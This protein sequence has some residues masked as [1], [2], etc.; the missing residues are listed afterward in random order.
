MSSFP[1]IPAISQSRQPLYNAIAWVHAVLTHHLDAHEGEA[2]AATPPPCPSLE[3][4]SQHL[5]LS[6]FEAKIVLLC[7][8]MELEPSCAALCAQIARNP[9]KP[10]PTLGLALQVFADADWDILA[11]HRPLWTWKLLQVEE[12]PNPTQARIALEHRILTYLLDVQ[13]LDPKLQAWMQPLGGGLADLAPS[14][15]QIVQRVVNTWQSGK[16]ALVQLC[17][18]DELAKQ[19]IAQIIAQSLG[20]QIYRLQAS[21]LPLT[22]PE[23]VDLKQRWHREAILSQA[24]L[25]IDSDRNPAS[26]S[27]QIEPLTL[28]TTDLNVPLILSSSE[29]FAVRQRTTLTYD[30]ASLTH[31]EKRTI[32]QQNLGDRAAELNGQ[33]EPIIAQ[34]NLNSHMIQAACAATQKIPLETLPETL[35]DYCRSQARPQ[36]EHLAQRID[37]RASWNDLILPSREKAVLHAIAT[38]VKRR[39][40]V[41]EAWGFSQ[42]SSRG[43]GISALFAGPSGTGKTMAAEVLAQEFNLDLYRIDLSAVSSKYIGETE[44]NLR[45]IFDAAESGGA[46]LLFDEADALFGKRTQVASSHDRHANLEVSYLLQRMEAY[47]G[48]AILTTNLKE[49]LDQAFIRRLRFIL[50]FPYPQAAARAEI[51]SRIFPTQTPTQNLDYE[52]LGQ[53]DMAGG[54]IRSIALNAAFIA[55]DAQ[56]PITMQHILQAAQAECTKIG[57]SLTNNEIRYWFE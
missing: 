2:P 37:C 35:W 10:Y 34:F 26:S 9:Q 5:G 12:H 28:W 43:L 45:Q 3:H 39:A 15:V 16:L 50:N 47:Q 6:P 52:R 4:L 33:L 46:V 44:K 48:L 56:H 7:A 27:G 55:A 53:L 32:W 57:R 51:W 41:Y 36:L 25:F 40:T 20:L 22:I 8:A 49:S 13:S 11:V 18:S 1:N 24:I 31:L 42:K 30:V 19:A 54:N 21:T 38:Q 29:R 14:Q 17:G 23:L